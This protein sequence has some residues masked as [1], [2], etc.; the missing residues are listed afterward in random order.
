M[1]NIFGIT[2]RALPTKIADS[3]AQQARVSSYGDQY[4]VPLTSGT[5]GLADEGSYFKA[6][7][8]TV[9]TGIIHALT[10][11][12]SATAALFVLRNTDAEGAKRLYLDYVRLHCVGTAPAA[13]TSV[14]LAVTVDNTNRF[15]S[16]GSAITPV[17]VNMDSVTATIAALN[18]G[19]VVAT[20]ASGSVRLVSRVALPARAAPA[21][22]SG[23][24]LLFNFGQVNS[25]AINPVGAAAPATA[26]AAITASIGP[27]VIGGGDSLLF[28]LFYP[29]ATTTAPTYEFE[30]GWWER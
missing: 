15:S 11:A 3:I 28:H 16:G 21:L 23:D 5:Y 12:W 14:Q 22:I 27:I 30:I 9:S 17:N 20:A 29:A 6:T 8:P 2:R 1:P 13:T 19:A 7:N 18:F 26:Q 4:I 24:L 10:T 25:F